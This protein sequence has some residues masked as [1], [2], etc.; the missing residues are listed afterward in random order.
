MAV[1]HDLAVAIVAQV[2]NNEIACFGF[3]KLGKLQSIPRTQKP[4]RFDRLT[5]WEPIKPPAPQTKAVFVISSCPNLVRGR[6]FSE[7]LTGLQGFANRHTRTVPNTFSRLR[8]RFCPIS[9]AEIAPEG[10]VSGEAFQRGEDIRGNVA[11]GAQDRSGGGDFRLQSGI[12]GF[13]GLEV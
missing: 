8:G 11:P 12:A 3:G 10:G 9:S 13:V 4:S 2:G 7:V 1:V 6:F 5:T